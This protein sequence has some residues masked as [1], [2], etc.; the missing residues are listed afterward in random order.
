LCEITKDYYIIVSYLQTI[1]F[2]V[3]FIFAATASQTAALTSIRA[4][5]SSMYRITQF[6]ES[7]Y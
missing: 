1:Q 5:A 7:E 6:W 4:T 3:D 2:Y